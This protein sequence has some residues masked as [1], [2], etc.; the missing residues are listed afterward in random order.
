VDDISVLSIIVT[1]LTSHNKTQEELRLKSAELQQK[2][3][4]LENANQ[5]LEKRVFERTIE[6]EKLNHDCKGLNLSKDKFLSV[7]SH[8]LRNPI[9]ALLMSAEV[10]NLKTAN[11]IFKEIQPLVKIMDKTSRRIAQQLDDLLEWAQ[12]QQ[13]KTILNPAK[14][15][16][17]HEID[18]SL[19]LLIEI[20]SQKKIVLENKV[21]V[22]IYINVDSI[23]LGSIIQN[24]VTNAIKFTHQNGLITVTANI[25]NHMV[26]IY[27]TDSGIGIEEVTRESLLTNQKLTSVSGTNNEKGTGLGLMLVKDFVSQNGGAIRVESKLGK[28]TRFI[29]T[30]P[31]YEDR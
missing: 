31:K 12:S 9:S 13:Q 22:D 1:D 7:I 18:K 3:I 8:D 27:V 10:L 2:Y 26:E 30:L 5:N 20:A 19:E 6:L 16:L 23:M 25:I 24:L 15:N 28:G 29:F 11:D 14:L 17:A 4:E 21:P